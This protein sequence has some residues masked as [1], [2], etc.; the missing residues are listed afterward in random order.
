MRGGLEVVG[1]PGVLLTLV[2]VVLTGCGEQAQ[3]VA[4]PSPPPSAPDTVGLGAWGDSVAGYLRANVRAFETAEPTGDHS[5]LAFLG[6]LVGDA[7]VVSL[8]EGSHG[9]RNHFQIK[10]RVLDY[11]VREE[12]FRLFAMEA[13]WPEMNRI[14]AW[15]RGGDGDPLALLTGQYFWTWRTRS[16]LDLLFWAR[17]YN[18]GRPFEAQVG[19]LGFDMQHPGM[20]IWNI[21]QFLIRVDVDVAEWAQ[22]RLDCFKRFANDHLGRRR[23]GDYASQSAEATGACRASIDE[24]RRTLSEHAAAWTDQTSFRDF[25]VAEHSARLLQMNEHYERDPSVRD[26]YM[27]ENVQW[28]LEQAGDD[29]RIVLW[30]HNLHASYSDGWMGSF[31]RDRYGED[32]V[33]LGFEFFE[34]TLTAVT[35]HRGGGFGGLSTHAVPPGGPDTYGWHFEQAGIPR[36]VLD[37][38]DVDPTDP[39]QR[40]LAGPLR[41]WSVGCCYRSYS[42]DSHRIY[43]RMVELYDAIIYTSRT[44]PTQVLPAVPVSGFGG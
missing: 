17:A 13:T 37:L 20:A 2:S 44:F 11:L 33:V 27:A 26:R 7:R 4:P 14:D 42:P 29:A 1:L 15:V 5:D 39:R 28:I 3:P 6:A 21:E 12:G 23:A 35:Q 8:G 34:G 24:V 43:R 32:Q 40:W 25:A 41:M 36:F 10:H 19:V 9:S 38:R 30:S 18:E 16:V 31:L 22:E